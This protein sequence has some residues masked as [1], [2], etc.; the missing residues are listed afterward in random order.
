MSTQFRQSEKVWVLIDCDCFFVSC[1]R[2][3]NPKLLDEKVCVGDDIVVA[4]SYEAKKYWVKTWTPV[5]EA[6]KMLGSDAFFIP[7]NHKL[8]S[9]VSANMIALLKDIFDNVEV[10][11]TDEA[12]VDITNSLW[13]FGVETYYQVAS[14]IQQKIYNQIWIP[15]SLWVAPT[16][17]LAKTLSPFNKPYG[18][19]LAITESQIN[20][21][22]SSIKIGD[23]PF[24]GS[25]FQ[26]RLKNLSSALE[27]KNLS[28][29]QIKS[30]MKWHWEKLWMELNQVNAMSFH[31][32]NPQKWIRRTYSFNPEFSSN[33]QEV[34]A[35]LAV[36]IENAFSRL[37]DMDMRTSFLV[38]MLR[39]KQFR[40]YKE[41]IDLQTYTNNKFLIYKQARKLFEK[42]FTWNLVYRST[43]IYLENLKKSEYVNNDL[44]SSGWKDKLPLWKTINNINKKYWK[45]TIMSAS[46]SQKSSQKS[47]KDLLLYLWEIRV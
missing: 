19:T 42:I 36:N 24:I 23:V 46:S 44:F 30:S 40:K 14:I 38:V 43:W 6:K 33:K 2:L 41:Y 11:S 27:F 45:N 17:L 15:V 47:K 7:P 29:G 8:Y 34:W 32:S 1:E 31:N 10:F 3:R 21:Y 13:Y 18:I 26:E 35:H 22:L 4:K 25:A 12:F 28:F 37:I 16:R 20:N 39:D 9:K 5:W